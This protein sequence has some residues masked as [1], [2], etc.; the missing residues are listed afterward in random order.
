VAD[1]A[2]VGQDPGFAGGVL[3]QTEALWQAA[4]SLGR[5]PELH[6]LR[7]RRLDAARDTIRLQG[8]A[9]Q[10]VIPDLDVVN[11][12]AA[13]VVVARRIRSARTRFVCAASASNGFGGVLT[14][15]P[16]G[17][18]ISTSLRDEMAARRDGLPPL[19]RAAQ[20]L[21]GPGL[22]RLERAT[23]RQAR[24]RW[25][26]SSASRRALAVA[27][28]LPESTIEVV[29]IPVDVDRFTPLA[30]DEWEGHLDAPELM[31][32][33]R[34]D[35]PRKNIRLLLEGFTLL[36]S[37]LPTATLTLVGSSPRRPL[38]AGVEA[39][40][41][42]SSVAEILRRAS[43]FVLPSLQEGFG[44]VVA[45]ALASGVPV[46]VTPSG[47]PEEL[48]R[49]SAGGEVLGGFDPA[50]LAERAL[51]MLGDPA[52]LRDMRKRGRAY[53]VAEH[54]PARLRTAL[55]SALEVLDDER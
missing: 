10:P 53:V 54:N 14:R 15:K 19:R 4:R 9:V 33:G 13:A 48:V 39:T 38:P 25:T 5:E 45:E 18:W 37:R 29:P 31:F 47:G 35:D 43:L 7:Y 51:A 6:Y 52:R 16:F 49:A 40:G 55:A 1:L 50:E 22:R 12:L 32:V 23:L 20:K 46:L 21:N 17:C 24:V 2:I 41:P 42:V 36:R 30:D 3:A 34:A 44:I 26:I 8:R 27:A 28:G 11:V